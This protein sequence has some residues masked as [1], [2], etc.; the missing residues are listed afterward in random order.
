MLSGTTVTVKRPF[1]LTGR[2]RFGNAQHGSPVD[3]AVDNVLVAPGATEDLEAA[4]PEGAM[5][6]YTLHFPKGYDGSLEGCYVELP[7]PWEGTYRVIGDP[8]PYMD[9]NTPTPWHMA[10]EVEAAHG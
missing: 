8:H 1:G 4:R 2:D 6:A 5:V 7:A 10:V 3:E 9:A